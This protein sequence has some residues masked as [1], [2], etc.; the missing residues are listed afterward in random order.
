LVANQTERVAFF[1]G[2]LA[3]MAWGRVG[4]SGYNADASHTIPSI[5]R[6]NFWNGER[7]IFPKVLLMYSS[8]AFFIGLFA[9]VAFQ[10]SN[11]KENL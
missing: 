1:C 7:V 5:L 10:G 9:Q 6:V 2:F 8:F 11:Y 4:A 3:K